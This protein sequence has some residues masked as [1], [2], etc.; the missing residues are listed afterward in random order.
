MRCLGSYTERNA[1]LLSPQVSGS[2]IRHYYQFIVKLCN[3]ILFRDAEMCLV[4]SSRQ[5]HL[6]IFSFMESVCPTIN[7]IN[8]SIV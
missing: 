8:G 7:T 4:F 2:I 3:S 5:I 6:R 1:E